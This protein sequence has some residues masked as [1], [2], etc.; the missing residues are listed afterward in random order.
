[1]MTPIDLFVEFAVV[2]SVIGPKTISLL[3]QQ[4]H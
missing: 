4:P 3:L 1:M 2:E